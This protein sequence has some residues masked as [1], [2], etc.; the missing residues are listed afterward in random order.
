MLAVEKL[1]TDLQRF[2]TPD[3]A[4]AE[5]R[6]QYLHLAIKDIDD[7][8]GFEKVHSARMIVKD[9]RV[10]VEKVRKELK[11]DAITYGKAVDEEAKRITGLLE[12]IETHLSKEEQK[13]EDEKKRIREEEEQKAKEKIENRQKLLLACDMKFEITGYK[14]PTIYISNEEIVKLSDE[15]FDL[16]YQ[17]IKSEHEKLAAEKAEADRLAKEEADRLE[18]Q[19]KDQ[20]AEAA[21]LEAIGKEQEEKEKK[22]KD[23]QE[24][25]GR[26]KLQDR[27]YK[28]F[29]LGL[30][31]DG[32][33]KYRLETIEVPLTKIQTSSDS[34]FD[35]LVQEIIPVLQ[36]MRKEKEET[37]LAELEAAKIQAAKDT[38]E[39]LT[40]EAEEK[41]LA[42]E[43]E[44]KR[45]A[46]EAALKPDKDQLL[47]FSSSVRKNWYTPKLKS[48]EGKE[49]FNT[50]LTE[51]RESL[52]KFE[53]KVKELK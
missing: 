53:K 8:E 13:I 16:R 11:A 26:K 12:P 3:T 23:E 30:R 19:R 1:N 52:D 4:I 34:E 40:R 44:K 41:R 6:E 32:T 18:R 42:E 5:M 35:D 27:G 47:M 15:D 39:R 51:I 33:E 22:L 36:Q 24:T 43:K 9:K 49:L 7:K 31:W 2:N 14:S 50:C 48:K 29:S 17:I 45:L 25:L 37:R 10:N 21:R 20:E 38:E 28:L 46:R